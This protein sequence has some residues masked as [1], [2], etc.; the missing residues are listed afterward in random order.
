VAVVRILGDRAL[1][2]RLVRRPAR[3]RSRA[4]AWTNWRGSRRRRR[5]RSRGL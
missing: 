2:D 4:R 1:R 3:G 5:V